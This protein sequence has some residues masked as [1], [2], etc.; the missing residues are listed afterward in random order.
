MVRKAVLYFA[1]NPYSCLL[2]SLN[3]ALG[4]ST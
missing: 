1:S 3:R 4:E 2:F